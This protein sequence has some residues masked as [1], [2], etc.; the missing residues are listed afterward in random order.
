MGLCRSRSSTRGCSHAK[1]AKYANGCC[2]RDIKT[3][4]TMFRARNSSF[5]FTT[6]SNNLISFNYDSGPSI[7]IREVQAS[8]KHRRAM[9]LVTGPLRKCRPPAPFRTSSDRSS[10]ACGLDS[11]P[12]DLLPQTYGALASSPAPAVSTGS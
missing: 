6:R 2:C 4:V 12:L 8:S 11:V 5:G 3:D 7:S 9:F 1:Y 10:C